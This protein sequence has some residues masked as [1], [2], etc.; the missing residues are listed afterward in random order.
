MLPIILVID[1]ATAVY[2]AFFGPYPSISLFDPTSYRI[3]YLHVPLAWN[4]YFAFTL[5]F[6][7]SLLYL[8]K[9]NQKHDL[10]AY[11]STVLGTLY[12]LGAVIC[13]M[14]WA[15][16]VW[17]SYWSWDPRQTAT[18]IALLAYTAYIS[19]RKSI[20]DIERS[21]VVSAV[22]GVSAYVTIPLSY[23]SAVTFRSLHTQIPQQPLG[24]EVLILLGFRV[25]ISLALFL[26]ILREGIKH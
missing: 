8:I 15:K 23:L 24:F 25:V 16:E 3:L 14:L 2:A 13:G 9:S 21:R 17:N 19:L 5:T 26:M 7:F 10:I 4:M 18:L 1:I 12:G 20:P 11:Y 6:V 22:F